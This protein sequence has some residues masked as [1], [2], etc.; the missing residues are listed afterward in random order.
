MVLHFKKS[1]S[2][3]LENIHSPVNIH[4][5]KYHR[6][7]VYDAEVVRTHVISDA[8]IE[9]Y[10]HAKWAVVDLLNEEY[11]AILFNKYDLHHWL[12]KNQD[13]EV[14]YFLNEAGSNSLNYSQFLAPSCFHLWLGKKGFVI[15]IEQKGKGFNAVKINEEKIKEHQ[16]RA[17]SFFRECKNAVFFDNAY[18]AKIVYLEVRF[19]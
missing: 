9:Q 18:D 8:V 11:G 13:D 19:Y 12:E 17:F 15:G 16:G 6:L 10:G 3:S 1:I 2:E 4:P 7:P 5:L 14:A